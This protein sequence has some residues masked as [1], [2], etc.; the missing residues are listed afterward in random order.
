MPSTSPELTPIRCEFCEL[1]IA[2][3][4]ELS[5]DEARWLHEGEC[6]TLIQSREHLAGK[7]RLLT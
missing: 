2:R 5:K 1:P 6:P 4:V 7:S 3:E